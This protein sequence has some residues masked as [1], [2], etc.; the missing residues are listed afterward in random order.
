MT[1]LVHEKKVDYTESEQ[2]MQVNYGRCP[3]H[4]RGSTRKRD[5]EK[6]DCYFKLRPF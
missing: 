6:T 1:V 2:I 3:V 5:L 4:V